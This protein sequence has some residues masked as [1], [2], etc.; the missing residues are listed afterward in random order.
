MSI[1][2]IKR[3]MSIKLN[4][5]KRNNNKI[6]EFGRI[7]NSQ[8]D[9]NTMETYK[10]IRTNIMFSLPKSDEGKVIE[11]TSS[12]PEEG[13]TTTA[14]NLAITFAQTGAKVILIDCDLR[15]SRIHRYLKLERQPGLSNVL[16]GF[17]ELKDVIKKNVRTNLDCITAGEIP[18]NP[19]E[20]LAAEAF[21]NFLN[22]LKKEYDYI[23][24]DTPPV[25]VV[26]DAAVVARH[27]TSTVIVAKYNETS[28]DLLDLSVENLKKVN[29]KILGVIMVGCE[30][31]SKRYGYYM[32]GRLGYKYNYK[33]GDDTQDRK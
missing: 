24:I 5:R 23:F 27:C 8:T 2:D 1:K 4:E 29:T 22:E 26:T 9:F 28:F 7:L 17:G 33:Y 12:A 13:K 10:T 18:P 14:I 21:E 31:T 15:K 20:I 3:K 30:T 19:A 16:C 32:T 25:A 6:D 11:I